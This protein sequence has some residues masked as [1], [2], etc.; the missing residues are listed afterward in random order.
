[1]KEK[2]KEVRGR[3]KDK[4]EERRKEEGK[5]TRSSKE[6]KI[7]RKKKIKKLSYLLEY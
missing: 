6:I 4:R 7:L 5:K 3:R 1:M 2:R